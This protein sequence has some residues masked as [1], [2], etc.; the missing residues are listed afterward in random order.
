MQQKKEEKEIK[1]L[2]PIAP[3]NSSLKMKTKVIQNYSKV[4]NNLGLF[5]ACSFRTSWSQTGQLIR[6]KDN[7]III[8][9]IKPVYVNE[10][11][12]QNENEIYQL[13]RKAHLNNLTIEVNDE[14]NSSINSNNSG[15]KLPKS[16][17]EP[18][19]FIK[20]MEPLVLNNPTVFSKHE[21]ALWTL[22]PIL[23]NNNDTNIAN[24]KSNNVTNVN[25]SGYEAIKEHQYQL[26]KSHQ[27]KSWFQKVIKNNPFFNDINNQTQNNNSPSTVLNKI[28]YYL[29]Q[30]DI[31]EAT[32]LAY[33]NGYPRLA[34]LL[35]QAGGD[36][37]F[38]N[39]L[40]MQLKIWME[41]KSNKFIEKEMISIYLLLS[42]N[43]YI[44]DLLKNELVNYKKE[45]IQVH[46]FHSLSL[47]FWYSSFY[48]Q[49]FKLS[50]T[51]FTNQI[52]LYPNLYPSPYYEMNNNN[53]NNNNSN[54]SLNSSNNILNS[55]VDNDNT[56][57]NNNLKHQ[58]ILFQLLNYYS[59]NE[60]NLSE[61][62][63]PLCITKDT[64]DVRRSYY[65]SLILLNNKS[66]HDVI[67][68]SQVQEF[69]LKLKQ[70]YCYQLLSH[71][72]W[73][74]T[75]L[76]LLHLDNELLKKNQID[77]I[78]LQNLTLLQ[79]EESITYYY[80]QFPSQA[81]LAQ[82]KDLLLNEQDRFL[83]YNLGLPKEWIHEN[84]A[85]IAID[86]DKYNEAI[87]H[88][89][90]AKMYY[91]AHQIALYQLL[92]DLV[93]NE[94]YLLVKDYIYQLEQY[95]IPT[96]ENYNL[97]IYK[98]YLSILFLINNIESENK[99]IINNNNDSFIDHN[100][101]N[102]KINEKE[103][104]EKLQEQM[105]QINRKSN[106]LIEK[107]QRYPPLGYTLPPGLLNYPLSF[108]KLNLTANLIQTTILKF[109]CSLNDSNYTMNNNNAYDNNS[110]ISN[111][112]NNNNN[113]KLIHQML[114]FD[115][116]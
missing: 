35:V 47:H 39:Y 69:N 76:L 24:N 65:L 52:Q 58:D 40:I 80:N 71:K 103:I 73:I 5:L 62:L 10:T 32:E 33:K 102:I 45:L 82:D 87:Q 108:E 74:Y 14:D 114:H 112:N 61:L 59:L 54:N 30:K 38:K 17:F 110:N 16:R 48:D 31:I 7:K 2:R 93:I 55:N 109:N 90:L 85:Y 97:T 92:P 64:L 83:I 46:W 43:I 88:F 8:E 104:E 72:E 9:N 98:E 20:E 75:I 86:Q 66:L 21:A 49:H 95:P 13:N 101:Y 96:I 79:E 68:R 12:N 70:D 77:Q 29:K 78:L 4:Y 106:Y 111:M 53:N 11:I 116:E 99:K 94:Q 6:I 37:K 50:L 115:E 26:K 25:N 113:L 100:N 84:K 15:N 41:N 3:T 57:N 22:I 51:Q 28:L 44:N 34:T 42:G 91:E 89:L 63:N 1:K 27:L 18:V 81:I 105:S 107:M 19:A 23:F 36:F 67:N 60:L 56:L